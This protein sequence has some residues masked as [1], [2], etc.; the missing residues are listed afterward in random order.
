MGF[1]DMVNRRAESERAWLSDVRAKNEGLQAAFNAAQPR[2]HESFAATVRSARDYLA[3][4]SAP[5]DLAV[6]RLGPGKARCLGH[7][8]LLNVGSG[9][10]MGAYV[11]ADGSFRAGGVFGRSVPIHGSDR[12]VFARFDGGYP[13][14]R[15]GLGF[16]NPT[17]LD[18]PSGFVANVAEKEHP[19]PECLVEIV[20]RDSGLPYPKRLW[21][22][23]PELFYSP[24]LHFDADGQV[25]LT[26]TESG[27]MERTCAERFDE[28]LAGLVGNRVARWT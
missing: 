10:A 25:W 18:A 15:E 12:P 11:G 27:R 23:G 2:A 21:P 1:E 5:P 26:W 13:A 9:T 8:W 16:E 22:S 17:S 3:S 4:H 7:G 20:E 28:W 19:G 24:A 6:V 14:S